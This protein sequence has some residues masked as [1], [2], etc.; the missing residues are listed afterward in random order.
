MTTPTVPQNEKEMLTIGVEGMT[1]ASCV[2]RVE[3]ALKKVDGVADASVNLA[4]ERATV[5]FSPQE[6]EVDRLLGAIEA[7]GYEPRRETMVFEV[8]GMTCASC[9]ARVE[10]ALSKVPGV[11][12][13]NV[14]LATEKATV[15]F[16]PGSVQ[17]PQLKQAVEAAGYEL[18]EQADDLHDQ[19]AEDQARHQAQ[20]KKKWLVSGLVGIVLMN[21][22]MEWGFNF[23]RD[24]FSTQEILV[25]MFLL[26]LPIQAWAGS[27]FYVGMWKTLRHRTAD[28]NTLVALGT[29]A[30]FIYSSLVTF[31]PSLFESAHLAHDHLL[32]DRPAVYFEAAVI[33]IALILFGR[34][35][36]ARA[37]SSTSSAIKKLMG[38][39]PKS[40]R[41]VRD[42]TESDI[43]VEEVVV[44]DVIV[45]RPGERVPVD[46]TV[47]DGRSSVDESMLT[48]ES[49]PG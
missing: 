49:I 39:R 26:A 27:Q 43:P 16:L 21:A 19:Q 20:L 11:A 29:S 2:A 45:V 41:V 23:L 38:L 30:A 44:G 5:T 1:C 14:N 25:G 42:G 12:S 35:L 9:V 22:S 46:G 15:A 17:V 7:A 48:G 47:V 13:A 6:V 36:E 24:F 8:A 37:K 32:G 34:W 4:T 10:K 18:R 33:I 40:A 28:M 3:R 31:W